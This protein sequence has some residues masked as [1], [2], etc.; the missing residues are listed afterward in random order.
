MCVC[1]YELLYVSLYA[2]PCVNLFLH[3]FYEC[4]C[5]YVYMCMLV[6]SIVLLFVYTCVGPCK[7]HLI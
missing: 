3:V 7:K 2:Y 4:A 6:N 5:I 1:L